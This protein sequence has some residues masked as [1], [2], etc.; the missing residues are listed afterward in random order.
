MTSV[1]LDLAWQMFIICHWSL[2]AWPGE[3]QLLHLPLKLEKP[4]PSLFIETVLMKTAEVKMGVGNN[5]I[6]LL[7]R[8][9]TCPL[10]P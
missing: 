4:L 1:H 5:T 8:V 10:L 9:M 3:C 7:Q 6:N 2:G